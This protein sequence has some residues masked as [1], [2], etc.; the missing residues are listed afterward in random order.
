LKR[1]ESEAQV[2]CIHGYI[3]PITGMPEQFFVRGADCW[4]WATWLRA[5]AIFEKDGQKLLNEVVKRG[6]E[7]EADFNGSYGYTQMLR[8]Q[9]AG[10]NNSWAIRWYFSAFLRNMLCLYPGK[11]YIQN[12]GNDSSGTH[13][14]STDSYQVELNDSLSG[15]K[16]PV[17]ENLY[18]R[19][20]MEKYFLGLKENIFV[21]LLRKIKGFI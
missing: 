5:W 18:A 7:T 17:E 19:K 16:I 15:L 4:G 12:I 8:D 6:M 20:L 13:C 10:K 11:S 9:I 2:A 1:Y 14:K 3:Y 21:R